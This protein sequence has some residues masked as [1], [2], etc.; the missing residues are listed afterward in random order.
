MFG[1]WCY[2]VHSIKY[3]TMPH[4]FFEFDI[5]DKEKQYFFDTELRQVMLS[6]LVKKGVFAQVPVIHTGKL[7]LSEAH[8]LIDH[9]PQY[10]ED[11]PEGVYLKI[12]KEGQTIGRYKLVRA[13]FVQ[14]IIE[15]ED[16]WSHKPIEVQGLADGIDIMRF[17]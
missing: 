12:E 7:S 15:G 11:R 2:A 3:K 9:A 8:K 5:W 4:Y 10:G 1:E 17:G 14:T 16:H 6:D 13:D